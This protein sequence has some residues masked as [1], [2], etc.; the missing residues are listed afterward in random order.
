M[1]VRCS[2]PWGR[3]TPLHPDIAYLCVDYGGYVLL[4]SNLLLPGSL[5]VQPLGISRSWEHHEVR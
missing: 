3:P 4:W 2:L 1:K 5:E